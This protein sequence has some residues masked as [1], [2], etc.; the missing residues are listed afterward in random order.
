MATF[1]QSCNCKISIGIIT[2]PRVPDPLPITLKA[3]IAADSLVNPSDIRVFSDGFEANV[4]PEVGLTV[5]TEDELA[6]YDE[7][8]KVKYTGVNNIARTLEWASA[9]S[10]IVVE[11]EDDVL[12]TRNWLKK[13]INLLCAA[14]S[15]INKP[16]VLSLHDI[17]FPQYWDYYTRPVGVAIENFSLHEV[18]PG[19]V[20]GAQGHIMRAESASQISKHFYKAI[21]GMNAIQRKHC[22]PDL[23][24][25]RV[26]NK[27]D[28]KFLIM[29]P[30]VL[31]H[32][33][34]DSTWFKEHSRAYVNTR[35]FR[36]W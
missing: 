27:L 19:Q 4:L 13:S 10:E 2:Y 28:Y 9:R 33:M 5:R 29:N 8:D 11:L 24:M 15:T 31:W 6:I 20:L 22:P 36:A 30:S 16:I 32:Q 12:F 34:N 26:C 7:I 17:F 25:E 1:D 21:I 23:L 3:C 14:E 35:N 18:Q